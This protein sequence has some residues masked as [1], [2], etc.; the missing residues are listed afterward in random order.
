MNGEGCIVRLNNG[1]RDFRARHD[2]EGSHHPIRKLLT[3]LRDE[4]GTHTGTGPATERVGNLETLEAVATFCL[5][6]NDIQ[7]LVDKLGTFGVMALGP[8]VTS[9]RLSEYEVIRTEELAKRAGTDGIHGTRFEI[10]KNGARNKLVS[11]GLHRRLG[12]S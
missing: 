12:L 5:T 6:T 10:D 7:N 4:Q 11:G 9:A 1:V 3:D 2:R 8:V